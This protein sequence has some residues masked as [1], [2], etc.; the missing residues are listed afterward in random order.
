MAQTDEI[1]IRQFLCMHCEEIW[2]TSDGSFLD[3]C[4]FC[5]HGTDKIKEKSIKGN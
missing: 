5:G 3:V 2:E 4:P 1:I